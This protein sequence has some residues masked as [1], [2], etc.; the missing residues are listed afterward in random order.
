MLIFLIFSLLTLMLLHHFSLYVFSLSLSSPFFSPSF[1]APIS[2][3]F[4]YFTPTPI[5]LQRLRFTTA[6]P[7][8]ISTL[9][10]S[11]TSNGSHWLLPTWQYLNRSFHHSRLLTFFS[12]SFPRVPPFSLSY[13]FI[14][15][16]GTVSF[17]FN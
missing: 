8:T 5:T 7:I 3:P 1:C 9:H 11:S 10:F 2:S 12:A 15:Q 16:F 14:C 4:L 6:S 13:T 17:L